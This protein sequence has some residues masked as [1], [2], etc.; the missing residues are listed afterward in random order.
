MHSDFCIISDRPEILLVDER[1][2]PHCDTGPFC[3]WRDGS[4]L[5]SIHGTM[6]P[7]WIVENPE[8]I[9]IEEIFKE[10][11]AEIRRI[12]CERFG[13]RK[14]GQALID[15]GKAKLINEQE[16]WGEIVKYY[17]F[18]DGDATMGFVH[19]INGTVEPDGTKH[20]FILTVKANNDNA[21]TAVMGTYPQLMERLKD[22]PN[23]WELIKKSVRT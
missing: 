6:V 9:T 19:V 8:Q 13:F 22:F 21:E 18:N 15:S 16:V 11:N 5:Y 14:F 2:R 12:M 1:N 20:E 23:K 4:A 10:T 3:K 17:H 7:E